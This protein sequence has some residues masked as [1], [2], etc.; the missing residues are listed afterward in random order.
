LKITTQR[1][2]N[3]IKSPSNMWKEK[4]CQGLSF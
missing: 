2:K 4:G 3:F 1:K